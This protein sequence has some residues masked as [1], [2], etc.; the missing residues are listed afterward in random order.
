MTLLCLS[1]AKALVSASQLVSHMC[2][3]AYYSRAFIHERSFMG[4]KDMTCLQLA[5]PASSVQLVLPVFIRVIAFTGALATSGL[6]GYGL[7]VM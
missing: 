7:A 6:P 1:T 3:F 4:C 2:T 5:T